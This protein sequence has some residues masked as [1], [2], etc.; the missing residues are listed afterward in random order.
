MNQNVLKRR[1]AGKVW[2]LA[3]NPLY[4]NSRPAEF[5]SYR[6]QPFKQLSAIRLNS[7]RY[8]GCEK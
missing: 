1:E 8:Q 7:C 6:N 4:V 3:N 2:K 5:R